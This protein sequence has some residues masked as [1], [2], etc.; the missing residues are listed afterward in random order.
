M[1]ENTTK[2]IGTDLTA[3]PSG[4]RVSF[5]PGALEVSARLVTPEEARNLMKAI[6]AGITALEDTTDGDMDEP[7]RLTKRAS[8]VLAPRKP[9]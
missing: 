7:L 4:Y 3:S 8:D 6:R 5:V 2:I 9:A 1:G